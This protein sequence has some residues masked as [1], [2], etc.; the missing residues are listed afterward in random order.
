MKTAGS[1]KGTDVQKKRKKSRGRP[2][3]QAGKFEKLV[4]KKKPSDSMNTVR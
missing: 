4:K 3:G 2:A 1:G